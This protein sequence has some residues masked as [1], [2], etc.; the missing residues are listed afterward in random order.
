MARDMSPQ[1]MHCFINSYKCD[2]DHPDD[3][4]TDHVLTENTA[5]TDTSKEWLD[6]F[7]TELGYRN[8]SFLTELYA[9]TP[10]AT[11]QDFDVTD[12]CF[13][14]IGFKTVKATIAAL[15]QHI[16]SNKLKE[17]CE[18]CAIDHPSQ[19]Q[20][21]CLFEP[22]TFFFDTHFDELTRK[23]FKPSLRRAIAHALQRCGL[24]S[25]PQRI[26]GT[27]GAILHELK[28]EPY[29]GSRLQAIRDEL[30]DESCK[31]AVYDAVDIWSGKPLTDGE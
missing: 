24:K 22:P 12:G 9:D 10:F 20:H 2:L 25:H 11:K 5:A 7:C 6:K 31:K 8:L 29:I 15:L 26:Q 17:D 3:N 1:Q 28:E 30:V 13:T 16:I 21:S 27:T 19:L 14:D 23:L 18:G 4:A